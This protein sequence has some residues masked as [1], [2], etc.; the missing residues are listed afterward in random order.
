MDVSGQPQ[1]IR[2]MTAV[3]DNTDSRVAL[4]AAFELLP[5]RPNP[6]NGAT[7]IPL[8]A[9]LTTRDASLTIYNLAGQSVRTLFHG[10]ALTGYSEVRWDGRNDAGNEV[11][12]GVYVARL[13]TGERISTR[14]ILFLQ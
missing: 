3:E 6:F 9:P 1:N 2:I 4:P 12:T 13:E 10:R 5:N 7:I 8:L 11:S 14:K